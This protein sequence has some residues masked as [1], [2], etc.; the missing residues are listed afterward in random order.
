MQMSRN[1]KTQSRSSALLPKRADPSC[2][3]Q[4]IYFC[5]TK[6]LPVLKSGALF[7]KDE[8]LQPCHLMYEWNYA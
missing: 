1:A 2:L 7:L 8:T 6:D 4:R 3:K 5:F